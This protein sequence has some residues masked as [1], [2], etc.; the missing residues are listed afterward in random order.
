[1]SNSDFKP[2]STTHPALDFSSFTPTHNR[3]NPALRFSPLIESDEETDD[4]AYDSDFYR[5]L[6]QPKERK[7]KL[8]TTNDATYSSFDAI[9]VR[10]R[11]NSSNF[12]LAPEPPFDSLHNKKHLFLENTT[13]LT[14]LVVYTLPYVFLVFSVLLSS[15]S[16]LS[17]TQTILRGPLVNVTL[18]ITRLP[19][20]SPFFFVDAQYANVPASTLDLIS[21]EQLSYSA[22]L[23]AG[24]TK[25]INI[26]D[27]SMLM[28]CSPNPNPNPSSSSVSVAT[29]NCTSRL[30]DLF[31]EEPGRVYL[32]LD[33][34]NLVLSLTYN[35]NRS[36]TLPA[37]EVQVEAEAEA[38][39]RI[40]H[41]SKTYDRITTTVRILTLSAT[42]AALIFFVLALSETQSPSTH[43]FYSPY[44][45]VPE[46][47]YIVVLLVSL[48]LMLNPWMVFLS[49]LRK[50]STIPVADLHFAAD[51][52][53][54]VGLAGTLFAWACLVEGLRFHTGQAIKKRHA[55]QNLLKQTEETVGHLSEVSAE[56]S[57]SVKKSKNLNGTKIHI[58]PRRLSQQTQLKTPEKRRTARRLSSIHTNSNSALVLRHDPCGEFWDFFLA[59]K[60]NLSVIH[61][62]VLF[63]SLYSRFGRPDEANV[64]MYVISCVLQLLVLASWL[65]MIC[66]GSLETRLILKKE[67]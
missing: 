9:I 15:S 50:T 19:R 3:H 20:S 40:T 13:T 41:R 58:S 43:W 54:G 56:R 26:V 57:E 48:V 59:S 39:Y 42:I 23:S 64:W 35:L 61:L 2:A 45:L 18:P 8:S 30:V 27:A 5:P 33:T 34:T 32:P 51:L 6:K 12:Q 28:E 10:R 29:Y 65:L 38:E 62:F 31:F 44:V 11:N 24:A 67:R 17:Q 63:A 16:T 21:S 1:M 53:F 46:R 4:E 7:Q 55:Q 66:G 14:T 47:R 22:I 25:I 52:F 60:I 36:T 49:L 37:A